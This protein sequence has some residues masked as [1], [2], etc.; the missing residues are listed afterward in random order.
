MT[1]PCLR[2]SATR[3]SRKARNSRRMRN[4]ALRCTSWMAVHC[5]SLILC[6]GPFHMYPALLTRMWMSPNS[7]SAAPMK[8]LG[9]SAAVTLPGKATA[10]PPPS[11]MARAAASASAESMSLTNTRAPSTASFRVTLRPMPRPPPVTSATLP[12]SRLMFSSS[13]D[14]ASFGLGRCVSKQHPRRVSNTRPRRCRQGVTCG[15][16]DAQ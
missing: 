15:A 14:H 1:V 4:G 16:K 3:T 8:R 5:S 7:S 12:L 2:S 6:N 13:F 10:A 11:L 9:K